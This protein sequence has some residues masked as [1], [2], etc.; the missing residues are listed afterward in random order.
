MNND[1]DIN[2]CSVKEQLD[3]LD[4]IDFNLIDNYCNN[5][6]EKEIFDEKLG[7]IPTKIKQ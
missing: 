4:K 3:I 5:Q 2:K 1:F 6:I 7:L